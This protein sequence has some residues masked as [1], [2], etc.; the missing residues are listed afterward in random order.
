MKIRN[1]IQK[2]RKKESIDQKS[3]LSLTIYMHIYY[4]QAL[5][6]TCIY[7]NIYIHMHIYNLEHLLICNNS[8]KIWYLLF[9]N[10]KGNILK[11]KIFE[12][13][14]NRNL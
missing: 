14:D 5:I 10:W 1:Q 3:C 9:K 11:S 8:F 12:D 13:I 4:L 2:Y 6:Y 7:I